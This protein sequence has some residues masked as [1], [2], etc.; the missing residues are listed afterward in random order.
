MLGS[1]DGKAG[2]LANEGYF[3]QLVE[4]MSS[5][6]ERQ[7]ASEQKEGLQKKLLDIRVEAAWAAAE[8]EKAA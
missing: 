2:I 4:R 5:D 8:L 7:P 6:V 3:F 1:A